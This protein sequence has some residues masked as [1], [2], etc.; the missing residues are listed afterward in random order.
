MF[1]QKTNDYTKYMPPLNIQGIQLADDGTMQQTDVQPEQNISFLNRL[2]DKTQ[3]LGSRIADALLGKQAMPTDNIDVS[4]DTMNATISQ[5]PRTG[6][7]LNDIASG[8]RENYL[9]RFNANN[10]APDANKNWATRIG[11]GLGTIGRFVDSPLGRFALAAGLNSALGYDNSLQEGLTAGVGRQNALKNDRLYRQALEDQGIDTSQIKG[12]FTADMYDSLIKAKQLQDNEAYRQMYFEDMKR[13]RELQQELAKQKFEY[14]KQQDAIN[15]YY[16]SQQNAQ[17]WANINERREARLS[18]NQAQNKVDKAVS[19][20][21]S[22]LADIDAGLQA[23]KENPKAYT[24][25]KGKM[26]ADL[27]NRIDPKG[28]KTRTQI[29]NITA[30]YRKWLTGAQMSDQERKAYERFL[31]APTD[32]ANIITAKLQGMKESIERK[33]SALMQNSNVVQATNEGWAF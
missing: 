15:N 13:N 19:E 1:R 3:G 10:L 11:E 14:D 22:T 17:G 7:V 5:N 31:P 30:V 6:G 8:Y 24:Y 20:N 26:G 33:N 4:G 28:V 21:M 16:R 18:R 32:N 9:N 12:N 2:T 25:L 29:D 23:I 27:A